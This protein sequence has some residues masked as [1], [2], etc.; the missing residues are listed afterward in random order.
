MVCHFSCFCC[1]K[2][3]YFNDQSFWPYLTRRVSISSLRICH[4]SI[5]GRTCAVCFIRSSSRISSFVWVLSEYYRTKAF[6]FFSLSHDACS[7]YFNQDIK[8]EF[9]SMLFSSI[10]FVFSELNDFCFSY[11][12]ALFFESFIDF[13]D[14]EN[15]PC[16]PVRVLLY[17]F[18]G[19]LET[20]ELI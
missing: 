6:R 2:H 10:T 4:I 17:N 3:I 7:S 1:S 20:F 11:E 16:E 12:F 15:V 9:T 5:S 13:I 19:D 18:P 8:G 14:I